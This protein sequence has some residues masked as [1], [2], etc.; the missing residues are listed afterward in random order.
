MWLKIAIKK[1]AA[2][3][4]SFIVVAND[5]FYCWEKESQFFQA[6]IYFITDYSVFAAFGCSFL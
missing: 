6:N 1:T 5:Y 4:Y 2:G 3:L